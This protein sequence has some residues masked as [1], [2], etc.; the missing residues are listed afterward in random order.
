MLQRS[1]H[2]IE[3]KRKQICGC[4]TYIYFYSAH[5]IDQNIYTLRYIIKLSITSHNKALDLV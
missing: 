5:M 3:R 2:V 1:V 4:K